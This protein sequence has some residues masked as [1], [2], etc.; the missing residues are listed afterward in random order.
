MLFIL[1]IAMLSSHAILF[2]VG[3]LAT[4]APDSTQSPEDLEIMAII[5]TAL[6]VGTALGS[7]LAVPIL[8]RGQPFLT[9]MIMRFAMAES[10]TIF[11]LVLAM[12]GAQ[13]QWVYILTGL[14]VVAHVT[15][16]PTERERE[17][18]EKK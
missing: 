16:F 4:P 2:A 8:F 5:M 18:Y 3:Q 13:M 9:L 11:G 6:G 15:A 10:T 7:A 1:W 17:R 14:G 12:L